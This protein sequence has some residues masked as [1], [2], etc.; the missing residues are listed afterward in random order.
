MLTKKKRKAR[1]LSETKV[2]RKQFKKYCA[3]PHLCRGI[4]VKNMKV[5]GT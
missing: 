4:F 3:Q 2:R 5:W 1:D